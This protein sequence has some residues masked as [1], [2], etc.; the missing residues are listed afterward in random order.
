MFNVLA[1]AAAVT[2]FLS[3]LMPN[4]ALPWTSW[5]SEA[6]A[7]LAALSLSWAGLAALRAADRRY[8]VLPRI[9]LPFVALLLVAVLQWMGGLV[10]FKGDL[11]AFGLYVGLCVACLTLGFGATSGSAAPRSPDAATAPL[12][13]LAA[14][15][16]ASAAVSIVVA[17]AQVFSLWENSEW[18]WRVPQLRR[19]G[20]NLGQPNHLATLIVMAIASVVFLYQ[21]Q[22]LSATATA[23]LLFFLCTGL[24]ITESRTGALSLLVL[25]GWW[26][27]KRRRIGDPTPAWV[28]M[29][30]GAGFIA[31]FWAWPQLLRVMLLTNEAELNTT[32]SLRL[33][34]WP[35]LLDA[36]AMKP[37]FG[38]GL[39]ATAR[40]HNAVA[41]RYPVSSPFSYSHNLLLDLFLWI[42]VP[43]TALLVLAAAVWLWRRIR[44]V[45][46][47]LPWYGLATAIPLLVHS[48]FEYPFAYAY[49]L[50][51][52]MFALGAVEGSL[53]VKPLVP[54]PVRPVAV[55]LA[56]LSVVLAWS[57][58]EYLRVEE[59]FRVARFQAVRI[60]TPPPE[61]QR[62][63]VHLFDQ[64]DLLLEDARITPTPRMSPADLR[65][66][67]E[68]ALYYPWSATQYRYALAL[69]LNG[70][71]Q[72]AERQIQV[73]RRHWGE[74]AYAEI[75]Q[76]IRFAAERYPELHDLRLP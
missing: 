55:F 4:H 34:V 18:I 63:R 3:W 53:G 52:A 40:A 36:V 1:L 2:L 15:V 14:I 51:P 27:L 11:W 56:M 74:K 17:L 73:M 62:P 66:V 13:S 42:G 58:V 6:V 20:S 30:Y 19:P 76:Q 25:L 10:L 43:L 59:D 61:H 75:K 45:D 67:K 8:M 38:W 54:L 28:G 24:A 12:A 33:Q 35:Q 48:M 72:E 50:A 39:R 5:H 71:R 41:D 23:L 32:S 37:W 70:E 49:F 21:A 60:G 31:L 65:T 46:R 64:L 7:F 68:A 57:V 26:L 29:G 22:R 69:A 47:P 9:V 44:M 16:L